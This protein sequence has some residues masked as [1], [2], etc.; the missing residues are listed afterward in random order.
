MACTL[1]TANAGAEPIARISALWV[2]RSSAYILSRRLLYGAAFNASVRPVAS[3]VADVKVKT[4]DPA[5]IKASTASLAAALL[6]TT[7]AE[8]PC[9]LSAA[10]ARS[11]WAASATS[12]NRAAVIVD[13]LQL[14]SYANAQVVADA[15]IPLDQNDCKCNYCKQWQQ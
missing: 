3:R 11:I 13:L 6:A 1:P 15:T 5:G 14:N 8:K 10:T 7:F 2:L 12:L 9:L 4:S